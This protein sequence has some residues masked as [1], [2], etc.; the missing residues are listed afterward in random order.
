M[1]EEIIKDNLDDDG[2]ELER[3]MTF[4]EHLEELRWRIIY[5]IIGIVVGTIIAWIF[6]DFLVDVVLLKP[7]KDSGAVLQNLRPFGQLFLFMQIAI[8]VGMIISIPN[9]FYQ[10]WQFISPALRKKERRY[11]FW[12]VVFS[13]VCFLGGIAFAYFAML[14]LTL[15]FATQF[16]SESIKNEFA[17]DEYMSIIISVM[18]AAGLVFELPMISF[19][20]SKLGIL[21]PS[22]MKKYRR[23]SIVIIMIL[24][25]F[26]TPGA[27]P[28]SQ[29]VLAVPLVV[30]YEISIIISKI[31]Q[32]KS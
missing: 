25:A 28:V 17:I 8:M 4:L 2:I 19:F 32:K 24:A 5:S 7:A 26:L 6:I 18:L 10:F 3:E 30:L 23:H 27:D 31:S 21:K 1:A 9:I 14:P 29:L 15:Q 13:S 20:L 12:I 16:G 22:F 11:I